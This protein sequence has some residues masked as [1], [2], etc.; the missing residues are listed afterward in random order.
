[1][2]NT[3]FI[4]ICFLLITILPF[5]DGRLFDTTING[6]NG[7]SNCATCSILLGLVDKLAIVY[8]E[9]SVQ[10]LE[11]LCAFLPKQYGLYCKV[12]VEFI[13]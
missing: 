8:N 6:V 12:A 13:G 4:G 5:I 2:S 3:S 1:M 10:A 9:T 11:R 7:G